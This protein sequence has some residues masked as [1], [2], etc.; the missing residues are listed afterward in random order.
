MIKK[1]FIKSIEII[2]PRYKIDNL[3]LNQIVKY[4]KSFDLLDIACAPMAN[5]RISPISYAH[6]LILKGINPNKIIVNFSTRDKNTLALQSEIL[7]VAS[8]GISKLLL[9]KGDPISIGNSKRSK[10]VF[11]L[12]TNDFISLVNNLNKGVDYSKNLI[13]FS[14]NLTIGSTLNIDLPFK[15]IQKT[16]T[17]RQN[18]GSD[19][20]ITQP[21][22]SEEDFVNLRELSKFSKCKIF[23]GIFPIK[24][25]KTFKNLNNKINGI[26]RNNILFDELKKSKEEDFINISS[27][28]LIE[29]LKKYKKDLHG[30]HIMTA[31]DIVLASKISNKV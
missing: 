28:Y 22:Y 31:G 30:V 8:M 16:I 26:N 15:K 27:K 10:E 20:L 18:I 17:K 5:L 11:E 19:F 14:L 9:V 1:K 4:N 12:R 2:P 13:N 3:F 29:L 6:N 23:A 24:N 21:L 25:K 7:G